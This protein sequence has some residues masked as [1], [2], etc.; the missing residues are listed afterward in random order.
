MGLQ[1]ALGFIESGITLEQQIGW[2]LQSNHYPPVPSS[3]V[4]VCVDV[5]RW[6]S[7]EDNNPQELFELPEGISWRGET[8]AP[9][10]SI[11]EG[12]HLF[13]FVAHE[14]GEEW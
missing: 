12:H 2:H 10:V 11:A 1:N 13:P 3:M 4:A 7:V 14:A 9:A 8:S 5:I 6:L